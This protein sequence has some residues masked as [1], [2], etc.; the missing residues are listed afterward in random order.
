[1]N[2][3]LWMVGGLMLCG[4]MEFGYR[5]LYWRSAEGSLSHEISREAQII[6]KTISSTNEISN[7]PTT[8]IFLE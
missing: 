7:T 6:N 8:N 1:M 5:F 4:G 2:S 3:L